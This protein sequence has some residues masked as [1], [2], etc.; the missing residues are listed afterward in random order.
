MPS[1]IEISPKKGVPD[2]KGERT[3]TYIKEYMGVPVDG[4]KT[5]I[6]YFFC[7]DLTAE[8]AHDFAQVLLKDS[9]VE[10]S[11]FLGDV[12]VYEQPEIP[13][14]FRGCWRVRVGYKLRPL[15]MDNWGEATR[16]ALEQIFDITLDL[17]RKI[18]EYEV[19]GDLTRAQ[20]ERICREEKL[21]DS[22][23]QTYICIPMR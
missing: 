22:K 21:A 17:V 19:T 15:I 6:L 13:E 7:D 4:V 11:T 16:R 3:K 1:V 20:I 9:V 12:P 14:D 18:D 8:Q 10:E 23:V 2:V 5:R